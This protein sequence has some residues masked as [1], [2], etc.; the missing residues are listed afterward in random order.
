MPGTKPKLTMSANES[1]SFPNGEYA[2]SKRAEKPSKKSNVAANKTSK[3][4]AW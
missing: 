3:T 2:L 4:V 1:S